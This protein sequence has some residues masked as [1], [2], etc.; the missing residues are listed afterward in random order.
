MSF[1]YVHGK[2]RINARKPVG[3]RV[4]DRC[5]TQYSRDALRWQYAWQGSSL[6]NLRLLVCPP[7][8]D[9]PNPQL[10]TYVVPPDPLPFM[11]PR[12]ELDAGWPMET[13]PIYDTRGRVVRDTRGFVISTSGG[14]V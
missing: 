4:C 1:V 2:E 6:Q 14:T 7:C 13:G 11:N 3:F 9:K 5:G 8:L 12:P 10:R